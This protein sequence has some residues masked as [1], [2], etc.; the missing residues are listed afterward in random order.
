MIPRSGAELA[1]ALGVS[2]ETAERWQIHHDLLLAWTKRINL[3]SRH[4]VADIWSRHFADSAALWPFAPSHGSWLDLGSGAGFP[5]LVIAA[6]AAEH[7]E[8]LRIT[9]VESDQ[10]KAAF[11][12]EVVRTAALSVAVVSQR[13][14]AA[15]PQN[16]DIVSARAFAPLRR[17]L[18]HAA[19]H[20][21]VD[22]RCLLHKGAQYQSELTDAARDWHSR[23][24]ALPNRFNA[25]G[26]IL[27]ISG[28]ARVRPG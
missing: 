6:I 8:D 5:G 24:E 15:P 16:A 3:V 11:L 28:I 27:S 14:E 13:V 26:V 10:R 20:L 2:R 23:A 22:G 12:R 4:S 19:P 9:L 7:A 1:A 25:E 17:L 21:A 18:A